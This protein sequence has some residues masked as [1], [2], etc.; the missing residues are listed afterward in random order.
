MRAAADNAREEHCTEPPT[1]PPV[2]DGRIQSDGQ[3]HSSQSARFH[4]PTRLRQG[5]RLFAASV[6]LSQAQADES[7][8][9]LISDGAHSQLVTLEN[10]QLKERK[11]LSDRPFQTSQRP[12]LISVSSLF[13]LETH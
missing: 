2:A 13:C 7:G 4:H 9:E 10:G 6:Q 3:R 8:G 1:Q 12:K 5:A 11:G